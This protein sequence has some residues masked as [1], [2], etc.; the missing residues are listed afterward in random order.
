MAESIV[1]VTEGSGKKLHTW[2]RTIG[3]N[4]IEDEFVLPGELPYPTYTVSAAGIATTTAA[5]HMMQLMAGASLNVRVRRI[6]ISQNAAAGA[7]SAFPLQIVRVTTAGT[8]GTALTARPYDTAAAAAGGAGMTLPTV[9][10]TEGTILFDASVWVGTGAIPIRDPWE[11]VQVP[12][13]QPI[14][15]PAGTANGIVIK[16]TAGIATS[17]LD[18]TIEF[19]E[20][21]FV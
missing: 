10:G 1:Q 4:S 15:I 21:N 11:W 16:N 2:N 8:G 13:S 5:S 9:K 3:A 18:I 17:T 20:T 14:I 7:V 6:R 19:A 12:S